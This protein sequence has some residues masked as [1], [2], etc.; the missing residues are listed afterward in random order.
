MAKE[1][2]IKI[3]SFKKQLYLCP[4]QTGKFVKKLKLN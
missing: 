1:I 3:L 4:F 2:A